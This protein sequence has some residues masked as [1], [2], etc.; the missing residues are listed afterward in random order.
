MSRLVSDLLNACKEK[1]TEGMTRVDQE[2]PSRAEE[3]SVE[4]Q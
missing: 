2:E 3:F 1:S 4:N